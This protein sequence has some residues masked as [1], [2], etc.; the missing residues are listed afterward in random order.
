MTTVN[1]VL[2]HRHISFT[3]IERRADRQSFIESALEGGFLVPLMKRLSK[4]HEMRLS[5]D[6]NAL[7]SMI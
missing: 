7:D 4:Q 3:Y 6:N 5:N 1:T 2:P